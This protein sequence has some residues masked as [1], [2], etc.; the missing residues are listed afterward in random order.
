MTQHHLRVA[1]VGP[2]EAALAPRLVATRLRSRVL[3][4]VGSALALLLVAPLLGL[5]ALA[6]WL[7]DGGPVLLR[8]RRT[9]PHGREFDILR[10]RTPRDAGS[11]G[12]RELLQR[13]GVDDLLRLI[14][15][16]KGDLSLQPQAV[17]HGHLSAAAVARSR[18]R[19]EPGRACGKTRVAN[20]NAISPTGRSA[21]GG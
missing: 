20:D 6:I 9:S 14:N 13:L 16:L 11:R 2:V 10:F 1:F 5:V 18:F 17:G 4:V 21:P 15:V 3:D 12:G 8:Q 7:D 19:I